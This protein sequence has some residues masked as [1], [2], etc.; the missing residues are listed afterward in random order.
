MEVYKS[1]FIQ[2]K[3]D[4]ET[5]MKYLFTFQDFVWILKKEY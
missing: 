1:T 3:T 5:N 4:E 2:I